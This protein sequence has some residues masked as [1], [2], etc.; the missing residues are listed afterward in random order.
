MKKIL[1][2]LAALML[3]VL[4]AMA[5]QLDYANM[6]DDELQA[7]VDSA[8]NELTKRQLEEDGKTLLFEHDGISVYLT[9]EYETDWMGNIGASA[10]THY[11]TNSCYRIAEKKNTQA[12]IRNIDEF[13]IISNWRLWKM[14]IKRAAVNRFEEIM[15]QRKIRPN[16]LANLSGVTPSTVY[17]MLDGKRKELSI[18]T[19]K[20]L[21]DG[22]NISLDDFFQ[23]GTV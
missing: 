3:T 23:H 9:G 22:L 5:K 17:S 4:P 21:C 18:Y 20:K 7:I 15:K 8:R 13:P 10:H 14:I 19:I 12:R 2:L 11:R 16:E 1:V 6:K